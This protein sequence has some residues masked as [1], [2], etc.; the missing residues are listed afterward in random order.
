LKI[1]E[2]TTA[3]IDVLCETFDLRPRLQWQEA[4]RVR[5]LPDVPRRL[6]HF[7]PATWQRVAEAFEQGNA[8]ETEVYLAA[9]Q[10]LFDA[11]LY[12]FGYY[13]TK[14]DTLFGHLADLTRAVDTPPLRIAHCIRDL[15]YGDESRT[16]DLVAM[17]Q[18]DDPA[19]REIFETCYWR[20]P[21]D[22]VEK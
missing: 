19:Y 16:D 15:T 2:L 17:V 3:V 9:W 21:A 18:S 14:D 10:L 6:H 20:D 1:P 4:L 11:N 5:F 7:Q 13:E 12:R 22:V 8:G